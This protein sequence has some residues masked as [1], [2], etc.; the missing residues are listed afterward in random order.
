ME[1]EDF[2]SLSFISNNVELFVEAIGDYDAQKLK[3]GEYN[4]NPLKVKKSQGRK[5][6]DVVR[7]EDVFNFLISPNLLKVLESNSLTGW[8]TYPINSDTD[9]DGYRGFQCTSSC[10]PPI[11][12]K[13]SGFVKGYEFDHKTWDGSDFFIPETT[14]MIICT[15]R[16][17]ELIEDFKIKNIELRNLKTFEWYNA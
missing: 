3:T 8:N 12:P 7:L 2:Y 1:Q 6:Y 5:A 14:M 4:P 15:R 13:N 11:R 16:A 9:L 17:K 10:G